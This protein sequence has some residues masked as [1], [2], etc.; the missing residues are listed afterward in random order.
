MP[1]VAFLVGDIKPFNDD[2]CCF[3][4]VVGDWSGRKINRAETIDTLNDGFISN[5]LSVCSA[6]YR[7]LHAVINGL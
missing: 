6:L 5:R 1:S 3:A 2:L 4:A 7:I